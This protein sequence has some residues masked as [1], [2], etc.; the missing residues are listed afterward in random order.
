MVRNEVFRFRTVT[1]L[2]LVAASPFAACGPSNN[3]GPGGS[4]GASSG[5]GTS[6][7]GSSDGGG[8][9]VSGSGAG[10][11]SSGSD[12]G[13]AGRHGFFLDS[14]TG[15]AS[16]VYDAQGGLHVAGAGPSGL[17]YGYCAS[18]CDQATN[19]GYADVA[20]VETSVGADSGGWAM[21]VDGQGHPRVMTTWHLNDTNYFECNDNCTKSSSWTTASKI[22][23][24]I[25]NPGAQFFAVS[26]QGVAAYAIGVTYVSCASSCTNAANWTPTTAVTLPA[27][28]AMSTVD[29]ILGANLAFDVQGRP[30]MWYVVAQGNSDHV[31]YAAC[32]TGCNS[33]TAWQHVPLQP[34]GG[35]LGFDASGNPR[36]VD[37]HGAAYYWC[38]ADCAANAQN[39]Q[40]PVTSAPADSLAVDGQGDIH[41]VTT[42]NSAVSYT[43]CAGDCTSTSPQ[44]Q[45][46]MLPFTDMDMAGPTPTGSHWTSSGTAN[47]A[48]D[49]T[50]GTAAIALSAAR[51][52]QS[53]PGIPQNDTADAYGVFLWLVPGTSNPASSS[54]ATSGSASGGSSGGGSG[55]S[56]SGS[57]GGSGSG[58]SSGSSD[59]G[60]DPLANFVGTPWSGSQVATVTCGDAGAY[61]TSKSVSRSFQSTASGLTVTDQ[62]GCSWSLSVSGNT[63]TLASTPQTCSIPSD[64]G[65]ELLS[66]STSTLTTSDG[67]HMTGQFVGTDTVGA[68]ACSVDASITLTR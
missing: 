59:S 65:T 57:D 15:H 42:A 43:W 31:G 60:T 41:T 56:G 24:V 28:F 46:L 17:R 58:S 22:R 63:A 40:G 64:A 32:D 36:L 62:R 66:L 5:G 12:G 13:N 6:G 26:P 18:Q 47:I 19:W 30:R 38:D 34:S 20:G 9:S 37:G 33:P 14:M 48:V 27:N 4:S 45:N 68:T 53:V 49:S 61:T 54:G 10:T 7:S 39:W 11:G 35:L 67:H 44:W 25:P 55:S 21:A 23:S 16:V 3:S 2:A 52:P 29:G 8:S 50:T 1:L 51:W